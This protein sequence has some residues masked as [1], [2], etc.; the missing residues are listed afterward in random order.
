[1]MILS[2]LDDQFDDIF[3]SVQLECGNQIYF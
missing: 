1:M 3:I 2:V